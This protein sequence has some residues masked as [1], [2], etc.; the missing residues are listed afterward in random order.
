MDAL[1][2]VLDGRAAPVAAFEVHAKFMGMYRDYISDIF[3]ELYGSCGLLE[4][5]ITKYSEC[6]PLP[7][8]IYSCTTLTSLELYHWRLRVPGRL[9][10]LR[11]MRSLQLRRVVTTDT[12]IRRMISRCSAME[13]LEIWNVHKARNIV[14]RAPCLEKLEISSYRP[15]CISVKKAPRLD[16]VELSL[17]YGYPEYY[18][19]INDTI[20]TDGDYSLSE[21]QEMCNYMMMAE[22]E[23]KQTDEIWNMVTFLGGLGCAKKLRLYLSHVYSKVLSK[24]KVSMPNRLPKKSYLLGLE[25]LTLNLVTI[26]KCLPP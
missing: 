23:H 10:S 24:A 7:S 16:T 8:P 20:D 25:T 3:R 4:L 26:M 18:W 19:S 12:D 2:S 15:L 21:I 5:S 22:R 1:C 14:I 13:H 17:C 6:Y 9:T 11:A